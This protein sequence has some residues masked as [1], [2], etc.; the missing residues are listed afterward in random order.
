MLVFFEWV[1]MEG[2]IVLHSIK[3]WVLE[4]FSSISLLFFFGV[5]FFK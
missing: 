4:N 2:F 5:I 3:M 1:G